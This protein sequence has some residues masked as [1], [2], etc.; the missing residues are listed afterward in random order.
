VAT[1]RIMK[2]SEDTTKNQARIHSAKLE[3]RKGPFYKNQSEIQLKVSTVLR[4]NPLFS[5]DYYIMIITP[6]LW[7]TCLLTLSLKV[8]SLPSPSCT[9]YHTWFLVSFVGFRD[10]RLLGV[11]IANTN[12]NN[13]IGLII[14]ITN[15]RKPTS[16]N[17]KQ[18]LIDDRYN[19]Q[20]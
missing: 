7:F 11:T 18:H 8:V 9:A 20:R 15:D 14:C 13:N 3:R 12:T 5:F 6:L 19:Q 10:C 4:L 1:A 17:Q 2:S 16:N